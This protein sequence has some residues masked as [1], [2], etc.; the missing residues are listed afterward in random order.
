M[1]RGV[2]GWIVFGVLLGVPLQTPNST[3]LQGEDATRTNQQADSRPSDFLRWLRRDSLK[4][5]E[6]QKKR[7]AAIK[8]EATAAEVRNVRLNFDALSQSGPMAVACF[9]H[10]F[11]V[12]KTQTKTLEGR[13]YNWRGVI[14][15]ARDFVSLEIEGDVVH[16]TIRSDTF[17]YHIEPLDEGLHALTK[18]KPP[19]AREHPREF[20]SGAQIDPEREAATDPPRTKS[21]AGG[22]QLFKRV[23]RPV[24][25]SPML[26]KPEIVKTD[27]LDAVLRKKLD[28]IRSRKETQ[29]VQVLRLD[30]GALSAKTE[31]LILNLG[32]ELRLV[33]FR[34]EV[35]GP[36]RRG[37]SY[38]WLGKVV[39]EPNNVL[40][41]V[42][43]DGMCNG[44]LR[45]GREMF[46]IRAL[47]K[48]THVLIRF[49]RSKL[50]KEHPKEF[51]S[52]AQND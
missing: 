34:T 8:T 16:G 45:Y 46:E 42:V 22:K 18:V 19:V 25:K 4:L 30:A 36:A 17:L 11:S 37:E 24:D 28:A 1:M 27:Q 7:L 29:H 20:P 35:V 38:T 51:P 32:Q 21:Q 15:S 26:F 33:A 10:S 47:G 6:P 52:G 48:D 43:R 9:R 31:K 39:L 44:T 5:S 41:L 23:T 40:D 12:W 14:T 50:P 3:I 13:T 49:D 2:S